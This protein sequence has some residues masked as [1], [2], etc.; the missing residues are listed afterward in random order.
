MHNDHTSTNELLTFTRE[1][2]FE[3][4]Q[5]IRS[6]RENGEL[7]H[8][9]KQG[10]EIV[11]SADLASD[12]LLCSRIQ[13]R[14]PDH[15]ILSEERPPDV[16]LSAENIEHLWVIDPIDGTVNYSLNHA[17]AAVSIAYFH[18]YRA[19]VGVVYNPF[20]DECFFATRGQGAF[21]NERPISVEPIDS[22]N[23]AVIATG[24]PY[25]RDQRPPLTAMLRDVLQ[26]VADVRRIGAAA[27]DICSVACGRLHAYYENV[28]PWDMA[29]AQLIAREAGAV[30]D[31]YD[32]EEK[33]KP[34]E[35]RSRHFM[36]SSPGIAAEFRQLL[37]RSW[38]A[39]R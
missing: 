18:H 25:Q 10:I 20:M 30:V 13:E 19:Q 23:R 12:D 15:Q 3:A 11:T 8:R 31:Y 6:M 33:D 24:F 27:L 28:S 35:L 22:L 4:G 37:Q 21:I 2:A 39:S 34:L 14:F 16:D 36:V 7:D 26:Q 9:Y 29:A 17:M 32:D 38:S 5:L 1:L